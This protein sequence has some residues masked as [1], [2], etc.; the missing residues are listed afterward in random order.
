M[1]YLRDSHPCC[2]GASHA[3]RDDL[4]KAGMEKLQAD[5]DYCKSHQVRPFIFAEHAS[6]AADF[7]FHIGEFAAAEKMLVDAV[8]VLCTS[9]SAGHVLNSVTHRLCALACD[10]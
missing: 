8:L 2:A 1:F 4:L 9:P 5:I 7:L 3:S 10:G 6:T